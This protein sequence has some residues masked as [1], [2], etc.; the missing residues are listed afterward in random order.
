MN[1]SSTVSTEI[2]LSL[3][4]PQE[5]AIVPLTG[6]LSYSAD[7]P[8]AIRLDLNIGLDE[9]V[10]WVFARDLLAAGTERE[11]G[12]G[13]VKVWPSVWSQSGLPGMVLNI[14]LS[15][16]HGNANFET[17]L[18]DISDFL[19]RSHEIVPAGR[20]SVHVDVDAELTELLGQAS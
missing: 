10:K 19:R 8:Y 6:S 5:G 4:V 18:R 13:D 3:I 9:P 1:T 7:D 17:P 12:L 20:E 16:P 11:D 2:A 15:G 14:E